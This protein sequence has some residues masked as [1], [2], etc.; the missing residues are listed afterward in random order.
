[1]IDPMSTNIFLGGDLVGCPLS[2]VVKLIAIGV[3]AEKKSLLTRPGDVAHKSAS[4]TAS[5]VPG[6]NT[7]SVKRAKNMENARRSRPASG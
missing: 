3:L 4:G 2:P 5:L 6:S 7:A 1:M